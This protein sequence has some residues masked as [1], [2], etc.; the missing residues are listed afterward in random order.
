MNLYSNPKGAIQKQIPT[1]LTALY[2]Q[3]L[4]W[5]LTIGF[6]LHLFYAK[7]HGNCFK[8]F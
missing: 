3:K 2:F 7:D 6:L 4:K 1:I 8:Q 5:P